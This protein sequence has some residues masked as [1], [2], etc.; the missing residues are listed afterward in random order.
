MKFSSG[1]RRYIPDTVGE[2]ILGEEDLL[3]VLPNALSKM[4]ETAPAKA[5]T[6]TTLGMTLDTTCR[7]STSHRLFGDQST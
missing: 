5:P 3:S 6:D 2:F 7:V 4:N 1:T